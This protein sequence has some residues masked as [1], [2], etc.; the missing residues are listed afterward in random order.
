MFWD[1]FGFCF[2]CDWVASCLFSGVPDEFVCVFCWN[3]MTFVFWYCIARYVVGGAF[4]NRFGHRVMAHGCYPPWFGSLLITLLCCFN[5]HYGFWHRRVGVG[6]A[7]RVSPAVTKLMVHRR[8][9][10]IRRAASVSASAEEYLGK[11][12]PYGSLHWKKYR[13]KG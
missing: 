8:P 3:L 2:G 7:L 4:F 9:Q 13:R 10:V 11:Q 12:A 1:F 6:Y 5:A